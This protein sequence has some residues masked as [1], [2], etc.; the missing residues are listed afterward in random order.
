MPVAIVVSATIIRLI[1]MP[2]MMALLGRSAWYLPSWLDA[3][4][5][6]PRPV[7]LQEQRPEATTPTRAPVLTGAPR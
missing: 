4:L 3:L 1:L 5:P 7:A 6:R 2:A